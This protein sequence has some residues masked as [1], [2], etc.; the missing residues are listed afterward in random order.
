MASPTPAR[1]PRASIVRFLFS[2]MVR[3]L[4]ARNLRTDRFGTLA[5]ILGVAMGTATVSVVLIL[6]VNTVRVE[7]AS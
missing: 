7:S 2:A 1:A 5:A 3:L 4:G 6:D